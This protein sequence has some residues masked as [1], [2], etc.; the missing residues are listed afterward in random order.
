M[1]HFAIIYYY[2]LKKIVSRKMTWATILIMLLLILA[3]NVSS[4]FLKSASVDAD[5]K[6]TYKSGY[7]E[8]VE[9]KNAAKELA[10]RVIDEGLLSEM[11]KAY[12]DMQIVFYDKEAEEGDFSVILSSSMALVKNEE[13][14]RSREEIEKDHQI[15]REIYNY[16]I[17]YVGYENI[18]DIG[19]K[20]LY[21]VREDTIAE[22]NLYWGLNEPEIRYWQ[23]QEDKIE[24]PFLY[25]YKEGAGLFF[26]RINLL[27]YLWIALCAI[28]LAGAFG[29]E[30][31][32]RTDQLILCSRHGKLPVY[33][34]RMAAGITFG[35]GG[36]V[37]FYLAQFMLILVIYGKSGFGAM[38]QLYLWMSSWAVSIGEAIMILCF[39]SLAGVVVCSVLTMLFSELLRNGVAALAVM[40]GITLF[41]MFVPVPIRYG[42]ISQIYSLAPAPLLNET[43]FLD[44]RLFHLFGQY[45]TGLQMAPVFYLTMAAVLAGIGYQVY[46]RY[47]VSGR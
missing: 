16:V 33:L 28:C 22:E 27:T 43:A 13:D 20:K 10:G 15:Y 37:L 41:T 1:K 39:V 14:G 34:A 30:H 19:E 26:A 25:E 8:V 17:N 45:L 12:G 3:A 42:L 44:K 24:K 5:G 7:E 32:R 47:Q 18:L 6:I 46:R 36:T 23:K 9:T 31:V 40:L 11:K 35:I 4:L 21:Q 29:E 38:L 2:E